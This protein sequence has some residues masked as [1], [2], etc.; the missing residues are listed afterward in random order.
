MPDHLR[1]RPLAAPC[2]VKTNCQRYQTA[3]PFGGAAAD[4]SGRRPCDRYIPIKPEMP[5]EPRK[6][7]DHPG[8]AL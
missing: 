8:G 6:A 3:V 7:H 2:P 5:S 1:C 4:F